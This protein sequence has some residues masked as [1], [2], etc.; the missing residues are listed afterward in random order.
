M[1]S[2]SLHNKHSQ[3][4]YANYVCYSKDKTFHI[5]L[6]SLAIWTINQPSLQP[7]WNQYQSMISWSTRDNETILQLNANT[8]VQKLTTKPTP[9]A[10]NFKVNNGGISSSCFNGVEN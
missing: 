9:K 10:S 2:R 1:N 3:I 4:V 6:S 7:R 5:K 8:S